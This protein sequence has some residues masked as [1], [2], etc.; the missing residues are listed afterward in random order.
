M[1]EG[2]FSKNFFETHRLT[3]GGEFRKESFETTRIRSGSFKGT[4]TREGIQRPKY[5]VEI[6]YYAIYLQDEW[7][8]SD[9]LFFVAGIRYDDSDKFSSD[10]S[11][12]L[13]FTYALLPDLRLKANYSHGFRSPSPRDLF[14]YF[15]QPSY[16]IVGNPNLKSEKTDSIDLG[17]ENVPSP[18]PN[19]QVFT[20]RNV[21]KA[22]FSGFEFSGL[23]APVKWFHTRFSYTYLDAKD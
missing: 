10:L 2:F 1:T 4:V 18:P 15:T 5:K 23:L 7:F 12:R 3:L 22:R 14:I 9:R 17:F 19:A 13:G 11:L 6:D 21:G 20:Y 8:I 16:V